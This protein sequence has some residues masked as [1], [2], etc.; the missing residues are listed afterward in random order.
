[1]HL[2]RTTALAL[3]ALLLG[4]P[5]LSACSAN[6]KNTATN[7]EYT[8]AAGV[9]NRDASV[10]V[11]GA[12]V[13][14]GQ[15]GAGTF[16]ATLVN[17]SP[18]EATSLDSLA[19]AGVDAS[20]VAGEF[21]PIQVPARGLVNLADDQGVPV[22]GEFAAGNFVEVR[23]GLS[24]NESVTMQVPVVPNDSGYFAGLDTSAAAPQG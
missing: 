20:L 21:A 24:S 7:R 1:M 13:V 17:T 4:T 3:G 14:S 2:R 15:D 9:N 19:G 8:P 16:I 5:A 22:T 10:D 12:V 18:D 6:G 23:L 11:L